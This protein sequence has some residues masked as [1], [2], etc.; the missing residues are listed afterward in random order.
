V[1]LHI[2]EREPLRSLPNRYRKVD[3]GALIV[4]HRD[5]VGGLGAIEQQDRLTTPVQAEKFL[6]AFVPPDRLACTG[7]SAKGRAAQ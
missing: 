6:I 7:R 1:N 3:A 5:P 2:A 4:M